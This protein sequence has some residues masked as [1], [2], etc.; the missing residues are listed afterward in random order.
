MKIALVKADVYQDLYVAGPDASPEELLFSSIMRVGPIGLFTLCDAT[1][2][3]VREED[4]PETRVW[5]K[6]IPHGKPEWYRQLKDRPFSETSLP[7]A[8][9]YQPGSSRSHRDHSVA[10]E[11]IDWSRYDV[12]IAINFA[13][14]RRIVLQHPRTLWCY[15]VGEADQL[16]DRVHHGYDVALNQEARGLVARAP[17]VVDF[18]YTFA[19]PHCLRRLAGT[20]DEDDRAR[21]GIFVEINS[22]EARPARM[23]SH[24]EPL[25]SCGHPLRFHRQN[26]RKNLSELARSKYFVKTRGRP[27][28]GNSVIEAISAGAV[29]LID[30]SQLLHSALPTRAAWIYSA[31]E[32]ASRIAE[33]DRDPA[34]YAALRDAQRAML[35]SLVVDCPLESLRNCLRVKRESPPLPARSLAARLKSRIARELGERFRGPPS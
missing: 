6:L 23:E 7:E 3:I 22:V 32:A 9:I 2:H 21:R 25:L 35:Q 28:R 19:G 4:T 11:T 26:I 31:E 12:V 1:F 30:P 34:A 5:E 20:T 10:A 18:P 8:R 27:I 17:G 16:L 33:L 15:L 14:P 29:V 13:V 24:L